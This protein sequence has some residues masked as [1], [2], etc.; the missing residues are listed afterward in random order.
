MS[1]KNLKKLEGML[2]GL[3]ED[4][5]DLRAENLRLK[6]ERSRADEKLG[7]ISSNDKKYREKTERLAILERSFHKMETGKANAS[8]KIQTMLAELDKIDLS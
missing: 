7:A 6:E 4:V 3:L 2:S 8:H 1:L 5:R